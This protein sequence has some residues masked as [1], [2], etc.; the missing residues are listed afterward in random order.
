MLKPIIIINRIILIL[1]LITLISSCAT[2]KKTDT[3]KQETI[4]FPPPP[5]T[6]R[7]QFLTTISQS[8]DITGEASSFKKYV[9]GKDDN[10]GIQKPHGIS[11]IKNKIFVVDFK[12][13]GIYKI[14]FQNKSFE[15]KNPPGLGNLKNPINCFAD[16]NGNLF[17]TDQVRKEIVVFDH[18]MNYKNSFGLKILEKPTD[19][20]AYKDK[21]YV[22]D[23]KQMKIFVFSKDDYKL[24]SSFPNVSDKDT[25]F[26]HQPIHI[27]VVNDIFYVTDFGEFHIKKFDLNGNFI[28]NVGTY[29]EYPGQFSRPKGIAVDKDDYLY[30]IDAQFNNVQI[31]NRNGEPMMDFGGEKMGPGFL[32]MPIRITIDYD[33]LDYFRKYVDS[34][35][36][37]KYLIFV[38]NQFGPDRITVYGFVD[39]K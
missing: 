9:S 23:M 30:V 35:Y 34:K 39:L 25:A 28:S 7:V 21:I 14:D 16:T 29:G 1:A 24:L 10:S 12:L 11:V 18:D 27:A 32:D 5:D 36:N 13:G 8:T 33:N 4:F 37:L 26:I 3:A 38:T 20:V 17:V 6:A 15:F 2:Q 22:S 19:V 31:F